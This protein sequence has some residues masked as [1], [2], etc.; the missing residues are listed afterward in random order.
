MSGRHSALVRKME[1]STVLAAE[2]AL[3][4]GMSDGKLADGLMWG[5]GST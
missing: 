3:A 1:L 5:G 2:V 4:C